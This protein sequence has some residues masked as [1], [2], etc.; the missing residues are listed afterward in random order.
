[1]LDRANGFSAHAVRE[2]CVHT[3]SWRVLLQ[4]AAASAAS[5]HRRFEAGRRVAF[6][7]R[8]RTR[9]LLPARL[10]HVHGTLLKDRVVSSPC[11]VRARMFLFNE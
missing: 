8:E 1:M 2:P 7:A 9:A 5:R 4:A 10:G 11:S 6:V 3:G